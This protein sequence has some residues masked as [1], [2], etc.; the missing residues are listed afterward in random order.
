[1][2]ETEFLYKCRLCNKIFAEGM[3]SRSNGTPYL[4][5]A[6]TKSIVFNPD[7]GFPPS[8]V[9]LHLNCRAGIGIAD[10]VGCRERKEEE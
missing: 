7:V 1:M 8:L 6:I 5:G 3:V 9:N 2:A 10:L 4:I